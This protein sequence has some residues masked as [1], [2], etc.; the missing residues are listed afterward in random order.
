MSENIKNNIN[1]IGKGIAISFIFTVIAL[2]ILSAVLTY[3]SVS[4]NI[5]SS[6]IIVINTISILIGSSFCT[7]KEKNRG[8]LKGIAVGGIYIGIIYIISS[9]VSMKFTLNFNSII[10][11]I[12]SIISGAVGGIIG[13]NI[14]K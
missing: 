11:I 9:I 14:K 6:S 8:M 10:I 4:E 1:Y 3:S 13:V 5:E 7:I 2:L 12:T